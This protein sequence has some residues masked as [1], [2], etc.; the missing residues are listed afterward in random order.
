MQIFSLRRLLASSLLS[1]DRGLFSFNI[2]KF[3][4]S[5]GTMRIIYKDKRNLK[6]LSNLTKV[7]FY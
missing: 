2:M 5:S 4:Y 3:I 6:G 1:S 7:P